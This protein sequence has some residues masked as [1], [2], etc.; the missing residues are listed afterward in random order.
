VLLLAAPVWC[1]VLIIEAVWCI[2]RL[3]RAV[4]AARV[5][6]LDPATELL[7]PVVAAGRRSAA[8]TIPGEAVGEARTRVTDS[9]RRAT[10]LEGGLPNLAV[11]SSVA[12]FI[13][14]ITVARDAKLYVG[15]DEVART[16]LVAAVREK[17]GGDADRPIYVRSDRE[18]SY[19]EVVSLID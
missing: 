4:R 11:I 14:L 5:D 7:D 3:N 2:R 9:M 18:V 16:E 10:R 19:G 1:W 6:D 15:R 12:P 8:Q 17:L 13:G